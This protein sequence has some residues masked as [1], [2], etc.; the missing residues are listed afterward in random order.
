M[1]YSEIYELNNDPAFNGEKYFI[2]I[3]LLVFKLLAGRTA[4]PHL[5]QVCPESVWVSFE[6]IIIMHTII[7]NDFFLEALSFYNDTIGETI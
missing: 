7:A 4:S 6:L 1:V 5:T 2:Q 3:L